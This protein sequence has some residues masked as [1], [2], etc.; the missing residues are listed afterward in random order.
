MVRIHQFNMPFSN[1]YWTDA[2]DTTLIS[3]LFAFWK[4]ILILCAACTAVIA[5]IAAYFKEDIRFKKSFLYIPAAVYSIL[6]LLSLAFSDYRYF[7]LRGQNELFEGSAVL[8]AYVFMVIFLFNMVDSERRTKYVLYFALIVSCCA[9][10][11]GVTQ[12][13]GRDFF[14]TVAGQKMMTFLYRFPGGVSAWDMIDIAAENGKMIFSFTFTEGQVYQTVYNINYVPLYL[15]LFVPVSAMLFIHFFMSG[16]AKKRILSILFLALFGLHLYNFF[17][18]NSASG[19]FGLAAIFIVALIVFRRELKKWAKPIICLI[20]VLGLVMGVLADRWLPEI[21]SVFAIATRSLVSS[22]YADGPSLMPEDFENAPASVYAPVDYIETKEGQMVFSIGGEAIVIT[23]DDAHSSFT[24]TD[25][26]GDQIYIAP[27][28]GEDTTYQLL[29]ERFHDYA[30]LGIAKNP[31]SYF[32]IVSTI[33]HDWYFRYDGETFLYQNAVGKETP[34]YKVP[35]S[36]LIKDYS[37]GS[38]RGRIWATTIPMLKHYIIKGAGADCF[39]F[40]FPQND[41]ATL[42]NQSAGDDMNLVTDKAHNIYMQYWVNTGLI[43]LLAWLAMVGVYLVGAVKSFR[44]RG[45]VD[46]CDF[47][48][49]GIFCGI[50]GFLA[51]AFFNDG[52][53]STMPMF[54]TMLGTGLA[55]NVRD[56]WVKTEDTAGSKQASMPEI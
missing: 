10:L 22:V 5:I 39:T 28:E 9:C 16:N 49:G 29:D 25:A 40:V 31:D 33:G 18:A 32:V 50:L 6:I 54:Y 17:A 2:T 27:I 37:F 35:H 14:T 20:V 41:Y 7:A 38:Y 53:V 26:A 21:K 1:V 34:L 55:I 44:K 45:F 13:I 4:A 48:N 52:S 15:S 24:I 47:A 8:L 51:T 23:R 19:Y 3:D 42:Y 12:A 56:K 30:T 36:G 11:L 46:F 43:S